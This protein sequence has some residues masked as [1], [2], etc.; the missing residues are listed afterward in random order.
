MSDPRVDSL[1]N[2]AMRLRLSRRSIMRRGAAIGLST[3][4]V[5]GVLLSTG[6]ASAAPRAAAFIQERQLN[7]LQATYFVPEGQ[8]FFTQVAQEWGS[9]NGVA[10]TTDYIAWPD[11]QPRIAAAVEGG[12]GADVIEMW[13][14]WPYLYSEN[15][16]PVEDLAQAVSEEYG[17]FYDWVVNTASVD[18]KWYSV[19][20]GTSSV[21][22]AYRISLFEEAGI[23]DPKNNFPKTYEELFAVGKTLKEMGKPLGQALGQ[24]LGDPPAFAYPYMWSYGA[25]EVEEDGTTV[26]INKPEFVEAL[27]AFTQHWT[28]AYDETGLSWDDA[29]NNRA[30]LS[31]QISATIN[32]S[33]VYLA[34][35]DAKEGESTLDYEV[36][37]EPDDIWHS[38]FPAGPA[39]QFCQLGCRSMAAMSYSPNTEAAVEFLEYFYTP[40][41]FIPWLEAQGGYIIPMA[42]GYADLEIY[43]GNP[44]LAPYPAVSDYSRNKGYAGP[45]NQKAAEANARYVIVNMFAQAIQSG[46]AAGAVQ[47][48]ETQLQRIYGV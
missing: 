9:Q 28:D 5:S 19:P 39:G 45:A 37:V 24:S 48:A 21:A 32:G 43:T 23:E 6:R 10:V 8:E 31:D 35:V 14:T 12:S 15:M 20:H 11:L 1:V 13:D 40:E 25:M 47:Q 34:A 30:F 3:A 42:P 7:T 18:G 46:D 22:Y 33:S 26:A 36:Q 2:E 27:Q 44:S 16:V 17:G 41:V 38:A 4:A 29:A